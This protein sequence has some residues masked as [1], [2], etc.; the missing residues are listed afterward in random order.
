MSRSK[1]SALLRR[2]A[3][4]AS[5]L[6]VAAGAALFLWL[7]PAPLSAPITRADARHRQVACESLVRAQT[8]VILVL[9]QSNAANHG[10][11]AGPATPGVF[12]FHD[13]HCYAARDPLPGASGQGGSVW[14]RLAPRFLDL[15]DVRSVLLVPLAVNATSIAQ[16]NSHPVLV[17]GLARTVDALRARGLMP[18]MVL[19]HQGEAESFKGTTGE[20]YRAGFTRWL[21][22]LRAQGVTAP[23]W[24]ARATRCQQRSNE[25]VRAQQEALPGVLEGVRAGP[26]LDA[27]FDAHHRYDGCHFSHAGLQA[28]AEAWWRALSAAPH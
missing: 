25:A 27:L 2:P 1:T 6:A 20:M 11:S 28:A 21:A 16:W 8:R 17:N 4:V 12:S 26:D 18:D 13:G 19:W 23:V 14:T 24:V 9:G 10:E 15:P 7:R 22:G 5:A 3:V